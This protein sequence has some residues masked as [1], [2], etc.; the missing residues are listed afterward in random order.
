MA[1]M[2]LC[3]WFNNT[4]FLLLRI[5][6]LLSIIIMSMAGEELHHLWLWPHCH[7]SWY[8][9]LKIFSMVWFF[10]EFDRVH[11]KNFPKHDNSL[12]S[13]NFVFSID[14]DRRRLI[15]RRSGNS[16]IIR[17]GLVGFW[18]SSL[19]IVDKLIQFISLAEALS[20]FFFVRGN[21]LN[22]VIELNLIRFVNIVCEFRVK[23][24][25]WL[26]GCEWLRKFWKW[27]LLLQMFQGRVCEFIGK[28]G[29]MS[30]RVVPV[31]GNLCVFCPSLRARSRQPV[32]RYKKFIADIF[33]RNQ[34]R[35]SAYVVIVSGDTRIISWHSNH[36]LMYPS[37]G[38]FV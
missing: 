2:V 31:C 33:P 10:D 4:H 38:L 18:D 15:L 1:A 3:S 19:R 22:P 37:Y 5:K 9:F 30:R 28:M 34:V 21:S 11:G 36:L 35:F 8:F 23:L 13:E 29:V 7:F 24:M 26:L 25:F 20:F 14:H 12:F 17:I 32:K 27:I 16:I 6:T